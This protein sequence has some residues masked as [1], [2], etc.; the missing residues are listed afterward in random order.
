MAKQKKHGDLEIGVGLGS[1]AGGLVTIN[2]LLI[3]FGLMAILS[4]VS[5]NK[6]AE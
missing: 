1:V 4:G 3:G 5:Q 6:E 2:P